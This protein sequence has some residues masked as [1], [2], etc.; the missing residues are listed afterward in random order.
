[1]HRS[2]YNSVNEVTG[3]SYDHAGSRRKNKSSLQDTFEQIL[4]GSLKN[5]IIEQIEEGKSA[6]KFED[7]KLNNLLDNLRPA[8]VKVLDSHIDRMIW[9]YKPK[10]QL[11][12]EKVNRLQ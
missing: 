11:A 7:G 4:D 5:E 3:E 1:M 8:C 9:K 10:L 2:G 6:A 12:Q